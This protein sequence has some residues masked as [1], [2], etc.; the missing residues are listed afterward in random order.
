MILIA[1]IINV[2]GIRGVIKVTPLTSDIDNF[3]SLKSIFIEGKAY[4]VLLSEE[5]FGFVYMSLKGVDTRND[6]ELLK[7]KDI[8]IK[9]TDAAPLEEG[10]YYI[11]D[12]IGIKVFDVVGEM[13]GEITEVNAY[14]AADV[15]TLKNPEGKVL[16]FP[17]LKTLNFQPN[18]A[19]KTATLD[20]VILKQVSVYED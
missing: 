12:L 18:I 16:R 7:G 8:Y 15:F 20:G 3:C 19:K 13:I 6:S 5:R 17:H 1:K 11:S 4:E 2:H 10:S 9:K 14:G